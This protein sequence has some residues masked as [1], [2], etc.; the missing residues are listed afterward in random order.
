VV[1]ITTRIDIRIGIFEGIDCWLNNI[2]CRHF[3]DWRSNSLLRVKSQVPSTL[4]ENISASVSTENSNQQQPVYN[5][6]LIK[7]LD[8]IFL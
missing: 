4:S 2:I 5:Q 1:A 8:Y 6:G 3:L 7:K